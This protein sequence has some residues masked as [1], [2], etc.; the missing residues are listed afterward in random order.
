MDYKTFYPW[1]LPSHIFE[2]SSYISHEKIV[3]LRKKKCRFGREDNWIFL[4]PCSP[5]EPVCCDETISP[6]KPFCYVY[7]TIFQRVHLRLP[8]SVFEKELLT[9]LNIAPAQLHPNNWAFAHA[10][11][12]LCDQLSVQPSLDAF[13]YL[14]EV[15]KL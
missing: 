15:K 8:L 11:A 1:P 4:D 2:T 13:L 12:I 14:F 7:A 9:E 3:A 6:G 5:D 10:F